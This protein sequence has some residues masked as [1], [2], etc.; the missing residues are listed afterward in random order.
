MRKIIELGMVKIIVLGS[1]SYDVIKVRFFYFIIC[2]NMVWVSLFELK[3][4]YYSRIM[5]LFFF[6][7]VLF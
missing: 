6:I 5:R 3:L 2:E 7:N 1:G 4:D